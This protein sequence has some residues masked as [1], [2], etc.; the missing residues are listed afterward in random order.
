VKQLEADLATARDDLEVMRDSMT[1]EE[2][3]SAEHQIT[4]LESELDTFR[5]HWNPETNRARLAA[6]DVAEVVGMW[7][8]IPVTSIAEEE[9]ERLLRM[10]DELH[11]RIVGQHEPSRRSASPCAA[12]APG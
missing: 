12:L 2:R 1:D 4:D 5:G 8:G 10:E 11:K 3:D 6:E 7:T 9:S